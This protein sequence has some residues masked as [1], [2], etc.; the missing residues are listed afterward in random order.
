M[1]KTIGEAT[2]FVHALADL[3]PDFARVEVVLFPPFTA[4]AATHAAIGDLP[5][6]LGAQTMWYLEQGPYTGEI[7][8]E[9]ILD[10]GATWV[11]IGHSER[12][13]FCGETDT[14]VRRKV[15]AALAVGLTPVVCVGESA[16]DHAAGRASEFVVAQARAAFADLDAAGV[17]RCLVAYEPVWAIGSGNADN[18]ASANRIMGAIRAAVDG[19]DD[20]RL[21]YGGSV[22]P[23]NIGAFVAQPNIDGALVG[24]ASLDPRSLAALVINAKIPV[25]S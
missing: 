9:M 23:E 7:A 17:A 22:K 20:A 8:P 10:C 15:D 2:S 24:S 4:L 5:I 18:P 16:I 11:L 19:L 12:R 6:G 3:T 14:D 21:L 1:H 13:Q 25:R